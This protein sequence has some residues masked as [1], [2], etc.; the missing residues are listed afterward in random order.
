MWRTD[1]HLK[2]ENHTYFSAD[3]LGLALL[4]IFDPHLQVDISKTK[5]VRVDTMDVAMCP[6]VVTTLY[7]AY[8]FDIQKQV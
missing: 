6:D 2:T 1:R 3:W 8:D 5:G 7:Y 4:N